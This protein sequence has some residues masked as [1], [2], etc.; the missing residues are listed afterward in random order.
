[1]NQFDNQLGSLGRRTGRWVVAAGTAIQAWLR[2]NIEPY[3]A[4]LVLG[5][6]EGLLG[7]TR[8]P[9]PLLEAGLAI[10]RLPGGFDVGIFGRNLAGVS[11]LQPGLLTFVPGVAG[12][13]QPGRTVF[14]RVRWSWF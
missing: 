13:Q 14:A 10:S 12:I 6:A 8:G 7:E 2:P 4:V 3:V 9:V 5:P 11:W 1:V